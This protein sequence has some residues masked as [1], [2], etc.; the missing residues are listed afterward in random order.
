M[1]K[2]LFCSLL[3]LFIWNLCF[4]QSYISSK[5]ELRKRSPNKILIRVGTSIYDDINLI[6]NNED[7]LRY[8]NLNL[9]NRISSVMIGLRTGFS[10]KSHKFSNTGRDKNRGNVYGIFYNRG[11]LGEE[12]Q[13]NLNVINNNYN[14]LQI[15]YTWREFLKFSYGKG[16][17]KQDNIF[18]NI[19]N[20]ND[21]N[22]LSSG[23]NL[24]F[25]RLTTD[26][27]FSLL[28]ND[29]FKTVYNRLEIGISLNFY[30]FK[31]I[32][33]SERD[34]I[35][36]YNL[37]NIEES[38]IRSSE[39]KVNIVKDTKINSEVVIPLKTYNFTNY[40][41]N[42]HVSIKTTLLNQETYKIK[43]TFKDHLNKIHTIQIFYDK[44]RIDIENLVLGVPKSMYESYTITPEVIN[45]RNKIIRDGLYITQGNLL[46]AD[47]NKVVNYYRPY[48][49]NIANDLLKY[50][51]NNNLDS[52]DNRINIAMKFVQDIPYGIPTELNPYK[53]DDGIYTPTEILINGYGDCD[54]KTFLFVGI[55]SYMINPNDILFVDGDNHFFSAIKDYS[56]EAGTY[57]KYNDKRYY[58]CETAGPGR[59]DFREGRAMGK[60]NLIQY[61]VK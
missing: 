35:I 33:K 47:C 10:R 55:L 51:T 48:V 53:H 11:F 15:G 31:R 2:H 52:R 42:S 24:R 39:N 49:K 13:N 50:L 41:K 59:P 22:V 40:Q 21:Y 32:L 38:Q 61:K 37:D 28:T 7:I 16:S 46:R 43:Y 57:F 20:N 12:S 26:F 4:S 54:S 17:Y 5:K 30:L 23:V 6:E 25:G 14:E 29:N 1:K 9:N 58:I 36:K 34:L 56:N 18:D 8:D 60:Y 3:L 27:N 45:R 44:D 19:L